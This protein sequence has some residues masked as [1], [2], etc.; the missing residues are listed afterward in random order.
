MAARSISTVNQVSQAASSDSNLAWVNS[1]IAYVTVKCH[2]AYDL[3]SW[4]RHVLRSGD[5]E[6]R[7]NRPGDRVCVL[8]A[9]SGDLRLLFTEVAEPTDVK[10]RMHFDIRPT[11]L[12]RDEEVARLVELG[13]DQRHD[14]RDPNDNSKGWVVLED[15][16]GNEFCVL[17]EQRP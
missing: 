16:E 1:Q 7:V 3:S 10:N 4:W 6:D 13:A 14:R 17:P 9:G 2:N 11:D 12:T 8:A 15:P 5:V